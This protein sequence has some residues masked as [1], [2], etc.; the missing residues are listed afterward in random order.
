MHVGDLD[1]AGV[2]SGSRWKAK[3]PI[4]VHDANETPLA[5][6]TV[7]GNWTN[8]TSGSSSCV[9]NAS[10]YCTVTKTRLSSMRLSVTFTVTG[11]AKSSMTYQSSANHDPDGDSN[12]TSI[13]ISY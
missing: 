5:N 3:V 10:G 8:G 2:G 11:L 1:A 13:L 7:Y 12:G 4:R 9:T 6:V